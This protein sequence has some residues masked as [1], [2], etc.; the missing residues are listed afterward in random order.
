MTFLQVA[1]FSLALGLT[2]Q[3][4]AAD[5]TTTTAQPADGNQQEQST[6][7]PAQEGKY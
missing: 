1:S 2:S 3:A 7:A 6:E 5:V 4:I